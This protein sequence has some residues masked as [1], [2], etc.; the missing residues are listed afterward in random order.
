M[1]DAIPIIELFGPTVQGEGLLIGHPTHFL[2]TGGCGYR[3]SWC[4]SMHAVDPKQVKENRVMLTMDEI[5]RRLGE[6]P[7]APWLTLTGG[8]PCMHERLG[9]IFPWCWQNNI[10]VNVESQGEFWPEWL[11][12][13]DVVTLSPK[14]PSSK[15]NTSIP[16]FRDQLA[17]FRQEGHHGKICVKVVVFSQNDI[18]YAT[19]MQKALQPGISA[20]L[21]DLFCYQAG[22]PLTHEL[23]DELT[24]GYRKAGRQDHTITDAE[25]GQLKRRV[26]LTR[27]KSVVE[28]LLKSHTNVMDYHT[29]ITCQ[30]HA[31]LWPTED[32]GK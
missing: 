26:I 30:E 1:T 22:S 29:Q 23:R 24:E 16:K 27:Y 8:D 15:M 20:P 9:E 12:H 10:H 2:R 11:C 28:T 5:C 4:D 32:K 6:L 13:C 14:G 18:H 3:C 17:K 31:L 19:A 25:L 7:R 21:Y